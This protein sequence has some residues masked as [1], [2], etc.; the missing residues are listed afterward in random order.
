MQNGFVSL[1][2]NFIRK[3]PAFIRVCTDECG[4]QYPGGLIGRPPG[5]L[6]PRKK[7]ELG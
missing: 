4:V 2:I 7:P 1:I 6:T 3:L 5:I